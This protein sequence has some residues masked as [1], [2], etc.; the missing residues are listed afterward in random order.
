MPSSD[1]QRR[2]ASARVVWRPSRDAGRAG[3]DGKS[4]AL[5]RLSE[6]TKGRC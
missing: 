6:T 2:P 4:E 1:R 3:T 5:I